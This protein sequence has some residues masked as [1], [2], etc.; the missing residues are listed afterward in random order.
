LS[1]NARQ[2]RIASL[3]SMVTISSNTLVAM[4]SQLSEAE[5]R[6][7]AFSGRSRWNQLRSMGEAKSLLQYV[8][9]VAADARLSFFWFF[10]SCYDMSYTSGSSQLVMF[11]TKKS[12]L[13]KEIDENP[14]PYA[15]S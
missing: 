9:N 5:E 10:I 4:A 12:S 1:P 11:G 8:F 7:R 13:K 3:E 14:L 2:A 6:E 15:F